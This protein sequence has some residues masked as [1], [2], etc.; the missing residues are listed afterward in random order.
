MQLGQQGLGAEGAQWGVQNLLDCTHVP[1]PRGRGHRVFWPVVGVV[2]P[3][4]EVQ[5]CS[6]SCTSSPRWGRAA[7]DG[8]SWAIPGRARWQQCQA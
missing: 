2:A 6:A 3:G 7:G 5:V 4:W 1:Q 8:E